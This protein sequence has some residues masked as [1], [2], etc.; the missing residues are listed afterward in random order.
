MAY[1]QIKYFGFN[2][3]VGLLSFDESGGGK[4]PYSKKLQALMDQEARQMIAEA[5]KKTEYLLLEHK[6]LLEKMAVELLERETLN[7]DD[8][9]QLIGPPPHGKKHLISP[10]EYENSIRRQSEIGKNEAAGV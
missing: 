3:K 9:E 8:V 6:E 4:K 7:Y 1:N 5:Y 2:D 10:V